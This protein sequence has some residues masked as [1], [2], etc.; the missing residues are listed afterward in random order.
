ME[1]ANIL[2]NFEKRTGHLL[3]LQELEGGFL[4]GRLLPEDY[5]LTPRVSTFSPLYRTSRPPPSRVYSEARFPSGGLGS[6]NVLSS[7]PFA[8]IIALFLRHFSVVDS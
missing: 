5:V 7:A 8:Y 3:S 2:H 4:K 6:P 1:A